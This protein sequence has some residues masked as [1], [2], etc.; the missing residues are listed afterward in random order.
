MSKLKQAN[1]YISNHH[2]SQDELPAFHVAPPCG[3]MNDPNGFSYYDNKIHLFYQFHPYSNVWGPM[4]WGH[5]VS[6]DFIQ[7]EECD[8]ALAPE[9]IYDSEGCFSGSAIETDKGHLLVYT[10]VKKEIIDGKQTTI[11]NQCIAIGDGNNYK[12][13]DCNPVI[14]GDML[15]DG[16]SKKDFRDPKIFKEED[17]Y[18][19][20]VGNKTEDGIPQVVLFYSKDALHYEYVSM[21][22]SPN[23]H[24]LGTMWE[25]PDFFKL[26]G[27]YILINSPQHM[28]AN[29]EFH[30]G[31]N[32]VY[33]IGNYHHKQ[34]HY[35]HV[36]SLDDGLDF[37]APQT[38]QYI[39]GR[40]IMIGW[41]QSWHA[42]NRLLTQKWAGM[43]TIPRELRLVDGRIYQS[44]VKEI[45]NYYQNSVNYFDKIISGS[46]MID[47]IK[48][49]I[50]DMTID[51]LDDDYDEFIISIACD[52][53]FHTDFTINKKKNIFEI[54]RTFSGMQHD[55]IG[56]KKVKNKTGDQHIKLRFIMDKYSFEIFVNEGKQVFSTNFYTPLEANDIR[57]YC[58]GKVH[59]NIE[60]HDLMFK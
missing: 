1:E 37:Y 4:H 29:D 39:D 51:I 42:N 52:D 26:D 27:E 48:G 40:R 22:A 24:S 28:Y 36:Y 46:C 50:M 14:I 45:E 16:F 6:K 18:Y 17:G 41:M 10:G 32:S 5:V 56:I 54:D 44:P 47:G 38:M 13:L 55:T 35:N 8:V 11:Q 2:L 59:I 58:D 31:N 53:K 57:F 60:K 49:R 43:M 12:K 25:C 19:L 34:F 7:W 20:V 30:N 23:N 21:L 9:D 3:W 33:Y 15:P